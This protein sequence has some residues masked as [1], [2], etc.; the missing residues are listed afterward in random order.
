MSKK[1]RTAATKLKHMQQFFG[2]YIISAW[3]LMISRRTARE[4]EEQ[5]EEI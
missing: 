2:V 4:I 3:K 5:Y 1:S